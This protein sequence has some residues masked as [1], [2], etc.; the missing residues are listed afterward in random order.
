MMIV[1]Q[2]MT[3]VSHHLRMPPIEVR[4]L[5]MYQEGDSTPYDMVLSNCNIRKCLAQLKETSSFTAR[6]A[7]VDQFNK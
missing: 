1:E 4:E 3:R 6:R 2:V 7:A 5:N